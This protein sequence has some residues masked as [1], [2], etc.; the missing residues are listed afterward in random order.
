MKERLDITIQKLYNIDSRSKSSSLIK[1]GNIRVNGNII[2]KSGYMV[3]E[4]DKIDMVGEICPFVSRGGLKLLKAINSFN[5]DFK[6]KV[7]LDIGSSTG[8]FTECSLKYGASKVISVDVGTNQLHKSLRGNPKISLY[9]NT[10]IRD[11]DKSILEYVNVI[12]SD[13]SFISLTKIIPSIYDLPNIEYMV[14]L[15]KPQFECGKVIADKY[16]GVIKNKDVHFEVIKN[17]VS[18]FKSYGYYIN[19]ITVSPIKG[20]SGNIEYLALF[21]KNKTDNNIDFIKLIN[22]AFK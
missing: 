17:V 2:T 16:K 6:D 19:N 3:S 1:T 4:N 14:M 8:G 13:V 11:I 15:I 7:V 12:V 5:L 9:E 20:G 22:E 18:S 10:D 21:S